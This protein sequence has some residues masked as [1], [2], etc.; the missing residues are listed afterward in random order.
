MNLYGFVFFSSNKLYVRKAFLQDLMIKV[1]K[2]ILKECL[3]LYMTSC[4][5]LR[6]VVIMAGMC[7]H[8][9]QLW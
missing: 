3:C 4:N 1:L 2:L 6:F 8:V 9:T 7:E 5:F